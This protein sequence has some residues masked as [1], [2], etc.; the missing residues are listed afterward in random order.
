[1]MK[2][3]YV[4][5]CLFPQSALLKMTFGGDAN[6]ESSWYTMDSDC[7]NLDF[8]TSQKGWEHFPRWQMNN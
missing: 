3:S 7:G 4:K 5:A 6:L 1:M 2:I 8:Q